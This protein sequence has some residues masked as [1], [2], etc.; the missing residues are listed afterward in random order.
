MAVPIG[1]PTRPRAKSCA[2]ASANQSLNLGNQPED[3]ANLV[4]QL[5]QDYA[6]GRRPRVIACHAD[7]TTLETTG[8]RNGTPFRFAVSARTG[9]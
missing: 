1:T 2:D 7:V 8:L 4:Q 5:L 9:A 3:A 6:A